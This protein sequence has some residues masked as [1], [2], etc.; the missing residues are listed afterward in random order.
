[1]SIS[2]LQTLDEKLVEDMIGSKVIQIRKRKDYIKNKLIQDLEEFYNMYNMLNDNIYKIDNIIDGGF[3][4]LYECDYNR[5]KLDIQV[6]TNMVI[7]RKMVFYDTQPFNFVEFGGYW[8]EDDQCCPLE[9]IDCY[10]Y[11]AIR[12]TTEFDEYIMFLN[13][14]GIKKFKCEYKDCFKLELMNGKPI[15]YESSSEE[16][17]DE[18]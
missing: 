4:K 16:E 7:H 2:F 3:A 11:T 13:N 18:E 8:Y 10:D 12:I 1:M 15:K 5:Y 17:E 9:S 14:D 6:D